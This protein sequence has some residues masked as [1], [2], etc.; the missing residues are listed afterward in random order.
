MILVV[1]ACV[2]LTAALGWWVFTARPEGASL[3]PAAI[4]RQALVERKAAVY[5]NL[6]DL[7]FEHLAGKLSDSDYQR[8]RQM[9]EAEAASVVLALDR[10]PEHP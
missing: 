10:S 8:T 6:K 1:L 2:I 3:S 5:E 9:L 4:R 7:H